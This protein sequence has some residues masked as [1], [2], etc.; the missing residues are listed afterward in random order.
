MLK[1]DLLLS[2]RRAGEHFLDLDNRRLRRICS[3]HI[4]DTRRPSWKP[5]HILQR[6][7]GISN[8]DAVGNSPPPLSCFTAGLHFY[9]MKY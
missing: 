2:I 7:T 6:A 1:A 3:T 5:N 9:L 8:L 4:T